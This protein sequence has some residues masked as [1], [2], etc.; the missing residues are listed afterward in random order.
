MNGPRVQF[1]GNLT[2]DPQMRYTKD[3][4]S[5]Y[6][7]EAGTPY[8][9]ARVAVN[10][11]LGPDR[12]PE[13]IYYN[14]T[15]WGRHAESCMRNGKTGTPVYV[16]GSYRFR[17]YTRED[18]SVGYSHDVRASQFRS[19]PSAA[20]TALQEEDPDAAGANDADLPPDPQDDEDP[21]EEEE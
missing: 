6:S 8:T 13:V 14:V 4:M 19:F 9:T 3:K 10:T 7:P 15:L 21:E 20:A 12:N 5:E 11:Y 17:E 2:R 18:N 1:F 16:E